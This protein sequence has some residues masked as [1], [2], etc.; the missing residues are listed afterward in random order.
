M[1]AVFSGPPCSGKSLLGAMAAQA[2]GMTHLEMDA[3]RVRLLPD[4][5]HTRADRQIA[6]RAMHLAAL[7]ARRGESVIVNA[8]Y[9]HA[10]DR[11]E[12]EE[13]ALRVRAP[14]L[15]VEFTV[16]A[17]TAVAR[18]RERRATHPGADLTDQ[19]VAELV[20]AFPYFRGGLVVDGEAPPETNLARIL[21]YFSTSRG[22]PPGVWP[23]SAR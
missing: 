20:G 22:L 18:A 13:A 23:P 16:T 21:E 9:S 12:I 17:A 14:L 5:A 11:R 7:L 8:S 15:L 6:Y 1:I 3:I 4:A 2:R 19:R 10:C